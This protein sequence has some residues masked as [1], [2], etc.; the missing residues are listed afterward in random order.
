MRLCKYEVR[1]PSIRALSFVLTAYS[2]ITERSSAL[3]CTP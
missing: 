2:L 3:R 1:G